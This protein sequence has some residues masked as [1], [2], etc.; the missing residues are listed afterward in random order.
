[1]AWRGAL[2]SSGVVGSAASPASLVQ[3]DDLR[4]SATA[5][6]AL[7]RSTLRTIYLDLVGRPPF[8]AEV[9]E[10]IGKGR[11]ELLAE[12]LGSIEYWTYWYH[13]QLYYFLLIDNFHPAYDYM[14]ELPAKLSEGRLHVRD[15]LHRIAL[16]PSF[17]LRNPGADTFVTVVLEQML[18]MTV[19]NNRREL[20]IGK[21][22]YDG[23]A[24]VFLKATGS[25][26]SDVVR[27][28]IDARR[29][30][31]HLVRREYER[32]VRSEPSKK[33]LNDWGRRLHKDP[34]AF[35]D[36]V[37]GWLLSEAYE[38]RLANP[39]PKPNR[40]FIR[41]L[42]VD[43]LSRLP[44][45][46]EAESLRN[47]LDGLSDSRPLRSVIVRLLLDSGKVGLPEKK[48]I[49]NPTEWVRELFTRMLGRPATQGELRAFVT[50]FHQEGSQLETLY[51][52]LLSH[53]EYHRY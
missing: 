13:E 52:A 18:G 51:Y 42:F 45:D 35:L 41:S 48:A 37:N 12:M 16:S 38:A 26:Q 46:D 29:A 14:R 49:D 8:E 2:G 20:E 17:D 22:L 27:I 30:M 5:A 1:M 28:A 33:E 34:S 19:Q 4:T 25:N 44:A 9:A 50:V 7:D 47:A 23:G 32:L 3:A 31:V 43:L 53:A 36:L 40:L 24:G 15:V 21:K 6:R 11:R 10:W 39:V